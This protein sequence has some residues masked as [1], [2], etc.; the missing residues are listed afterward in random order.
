MRECLTAQDCTGLD[1][2][3][4]RQTIHVISPGIGVFIKGSDLLPKRHECFQYGHTAG[5][6]SVSSTTHHPG[7]AF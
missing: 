3:S 2:T 1:A 7:K 5:L 4:C 6:V